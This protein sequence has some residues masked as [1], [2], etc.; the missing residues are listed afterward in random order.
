MV[1]MARDNV[2]SFP[3]STRSAVGEQVRARTLEE[4]RDLAAQKLREVTRNCCAVLGE[5]MLQRGDDADEREQ[6]NLYYL[7]A[8][9]LRSNAVRIEGLVAAQWLKLF[10]VITMAPGRSAPLVSVA[11]AAELELVDFVDMDEQMAAKALVEH[12]RET[13]EEG[14]FAVGRRLAYLI[15]QEEGNL[16]I[17]P[18]LAESFQ[19]AFKETALPTALRIEMLRGI[20][21]MAKESFGALV[22]D[23]NAF[24]VGRGVLPQ[25]RRSYSRAQT[26]ENKARGTRGADSGDLFGLLQRLIASPSGAG[27]VPSGIGGPAGGLVGGL[28]QGSAMSMA[29]MA[30][31]ME[32]AMATLDRLQQVPL[33]AVAPTTSVLREFRQSDAGQGLG[34]VDAVTVDIVATLFDF[35]FDDPAIADPIKALVARLQIPVLKVAMLDKSFFSSKAHP[36]RRLLDG[37]SRAAARCGPGAGHDDPLYARIA[38]IIDR[39]QSEFA[40]DA[41]LF[42][43]LCGEL[44]EFLDR[45]EAEADARAERAAPLVAEREKREMAAVAADAALAGWLS[46]SLPAAVTDLL[47]HEW[48]GLLVHHYVNDDH[49]GWEAALNNAADLVASVQPLSSA[50]ARMQLATRLPVLVKSI[51]D[52]L[53]RIKVAMERRMA[54]IDSLFSLHAA[55]LRG[56]AP[57]VTMALPQTPAESQPEIVSESIEVGDT[58]LDSVSLVDAARVPVQESG[59]AA[60]Q[61]VDGLRR[62]DWVEFAMD[63]GAVRY[64][65]SWISPE[66]GI[67]LFTNP[68][69]PR[70]ISVAPAAL[71]LQIERGEAAI[72]PVEPI[73]ERAV[74]RALEALKAA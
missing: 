39:V 60:Q 8:E 53:D 50:Q 35:I 64:R 62:G 72:V 28:G 29:T 74:H 51:H 40:H 46:G 4:A 54:L 2:V 5:H 71:A 32:Q 13:C 6:R 44:D 41:R 55:V 61:E 56:A 21:R 7:G 16:A 69:S 1:T 22:H 47:T 24:L 34:H 12:L 15:G 70:A 30:A 68:Q 65:L 59:S 45:H 14:L 38:A 23:L 33:V 36:A 63:A 31:A 73:F 26:T 10:D 27:G 37:I 17:E 18:I 43:V 42:D 58:C 52:G 11:P 57:V 19:A 3:E 9:T 66:R 49:V 48:R 20:Q 67:L 25:L